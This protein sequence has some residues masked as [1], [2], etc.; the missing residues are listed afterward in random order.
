M[1]VPLICLTGTHLFLAI[2]VNRIPIAYEF[3]RS[4]NHFDKFKAFQYLIKNKILN[5]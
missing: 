4:A 1:E 3:A 2:A 5:Y